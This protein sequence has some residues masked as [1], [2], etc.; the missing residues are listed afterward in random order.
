MESLKHDV[1]AQKKLNLALHKQTTT[2]ERS[3]LSMVEELSKSKT[4]GAKLKSLVAEVDAKGHKQR[5]K[6]MEQQLQVALV[7]LATVRC[8]VF[9]LRR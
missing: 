3:Q 2:A 7:E 4:E 1:D 6:Q 8:T 5:Y 9:H